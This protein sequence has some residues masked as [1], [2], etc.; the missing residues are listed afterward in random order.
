M[1]CHVPGNVSTYNEEMAPLIEKLKQSYKPVDVKAA[2]NQLLD[3]L[4]NDEL[5]TCIDAGEELL[6]ER[7]PDST[8]TRVHILISSCLA[9]PDEMEEHYEKALEIWTLLNAQHGKNTRFEP[10][11]RETRAQLD[12]LREVIQEERS[13]ESTTDTEL[14][15]SAIAVV[16]SAPTL[17]PSSTSSDRSSSDG[18]KSER[19]YTTRTQST[20]ASPARPSASSSASTTRP[21]ESSNASSVLSATTS[22]RL[23]GAVA[24]PGQP[25]FRLHDHVGMSPADILKLAWDPNRTVRGR[26][27]SSKTL[28]FRSSE[29]LVSSTSEGA[30]ED[31]SEG[32]SGELSS[33]PPP[34]TPS[35][36]LP[37]TPSTP[38]KTLRPARETE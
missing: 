23:F 19:S 4:D 13:D 16:E 33:T 6:K 22:S 27:T 2:F 24:S 30:S 28:P 38:S 10:F 34:S 20:D 8:R 31:A 37:L 26:T 11:L 36:T 3:H 5:D 35:K 17:A 21:S 25:T 7:I 29:I 1:S 12:A 15:M 9:D 18:S 32:A 14:N